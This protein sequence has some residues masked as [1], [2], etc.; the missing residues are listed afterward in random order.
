MII[1]EF[2][3]ACTWLPF[4]T[5]KNVCSK[6]KFTLR[7]FLLCAVSISFPVISLCRLNTN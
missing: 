3:L 7:H 5:S 1:S 2:Q 4:N 6:S